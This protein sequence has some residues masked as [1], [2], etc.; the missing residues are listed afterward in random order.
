MSVSTGCIFCTG[1]SSNLVPALGI[2][3]LQKYYQP[4]KSSGTCSR[5]ISLQGQRQDSNTALAD[6][7]AW[8]LSSRPAGERESVC[9]SVPLGEGLR[10]TPWGVLCVREAGSAVVHP[11]TE[12]LEEFEKKSP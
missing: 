10:E 3:S 9:T 6:F 4:E 2:F 8:L 12:P 11:S 7:T 1:V 5:S